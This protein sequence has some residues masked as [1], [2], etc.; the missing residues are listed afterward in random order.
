VTRPRA[1]LVT[2]GGSG[3]GAAVARMLTA[4]GSRVAVC[5][6]RADALRAVAAE[7][8]ALGLVCDV[9]DAGQVARV[10]ETVAGEFGGLDG[11]VLNA[12]VIAPG[13]VADLS[14]ADWSAMVSVNLT[15]AFLV[16]R[17]ALPHLRAGRGAVVSVA[18]V[19]A[20]R[21]AGGMGGYAATKAGLAMLTQ[22][23]AVDHAHEGLRANVVC[24]GWT[25]T[26]MADE[27]MAAFGAER[28]VG[29]PGAYELVTALVPQ[30]RP[31]HADEVAAVVA[32]LLSDAS[33][34]VNGAV[35]PVDGSAS[36]VDVGTVAFDPR[37]SVRLEGDRGESPG[38]G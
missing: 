6:R 29:V 8:G 2:G 31:A 27:E 26:E 28:G 10:V 13:G 32:W 11:L 36:A 19:A 20:L 24:P 5:G 1:V 17:A 16:A 22:S 12:G 4:A 35:I 37:V 33:S 21:A 25:I 7:T 34:Y 38:I 15:G 23:L 18:S 9:A 30:R 3:I 14:P